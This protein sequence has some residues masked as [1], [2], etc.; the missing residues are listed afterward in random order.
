NYGDEI[1][2][3]AERW[4]CTKSA[5][6]KHKINLHLASGSWNS[7]M[8]AIQLAIQRGAA[9]VILLGYDCDVSNGTHWHGDH[10]ATHNPDSR[11]VRLWHGHFA[12]VGIQAKARGCKIINASRHTAL[13][14]FERMEL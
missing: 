7:G 9:K 10:T 13:K 4:T 8:R 14:C 3:P 5:A 6:E 2:I 12:A 1:D 11:R